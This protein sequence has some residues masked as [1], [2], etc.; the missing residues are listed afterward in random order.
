MAGKTVAYLD[1]IGGV[2]GDILLGAMLDA[3]S[4]SRRSALRTGKAAGSRLRPVSRTGKARRA[5][6][7]PASRQS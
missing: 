6:R 2:S 1:M 5:R 4:P 7:Y 3:G